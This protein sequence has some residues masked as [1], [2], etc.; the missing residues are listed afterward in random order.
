MRFFKYFNFNPS[1][2]YNEVW[3][4]NQLEW[5]LS[6][7]RGKNG[8][9]P[10]DTLNQFSRSYWY[11]TNA[12]VTTRIYGTFYIKRLGIEAIRH[13]LIPTIGVSYQPDFSEAQY[14][15]FTTFR[16]SSNRMQVFSRYNGYMMGS[17][18]RGAQ[19]NINYSLS[20]TFEMKVKSKTDT[21]KKFAKVSLFESIGISGSYNLL[22]D[23]FN[24]S[25][26]IISARTNLFKNM[27]NF[28]FN[29][30]IDPYSY[31]FDSLTRRGV[32][33]QKRMKQLE[34]SKIDLTKFTGSFGNLVNANF[35][36]NL[37]L[38]P[39]MFKPAATQK[40]QSDAEKEMSKL[41][42]M[43]PDR[44]VD[45]K[46]PWTFRTMYTLN[47]NKIGF[48]KEN[49]IQT[50]QFGGDLRLTDKWKVAFTS[51]FDIVKGE[52]SYTTF[53]IF[54]DL[55]CWQLNIMWIPFGPNQMYTIDLNVKS[56]ILKDLKLNKRRAD[57]LDN[58]Q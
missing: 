36:L 6:G 45:F 14:G 20:N 55:H 9:R 34:A 13:Q 15:S 43:Y 46:L 57:Y 56:T 38:N 58:V 39:E 17:A 21:V 48:Q 4:P 44:Y 25:N 8:F 11:N 53:N 16:D 32:V 30:S 52:F 35:N 28:S 42:K 40:A 29:G 3:Y 54:R 27:I 12:S 5:S 19:G 51:N 1:L 31:R 37:T 33:V 26:I 18:P 23:S 47:Y 24:L 2:S 22:A 49:V 50:M 10:V 7:S 41:A